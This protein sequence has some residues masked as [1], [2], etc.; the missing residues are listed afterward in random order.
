[1]AQILIRE[2]GLQGL[3]ISFCGGAT[4]LEHPAASAPAGTDAASEQATLDGPSQP[5]SIAEGLRY[6]TRR[7]QT[8]IQS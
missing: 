1:M 5:Y 7:Y 8:T 4:R 6:F 3:I 2:P